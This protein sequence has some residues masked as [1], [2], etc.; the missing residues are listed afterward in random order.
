[1]T[2][3]FSIQ[4]FLLSMFFG[5]AVGI[6]MFGVPLIVALLFR[7]VALRITIGDFQ[8]DDNGEPQ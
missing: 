7:V 1:M 5:L 3:G 4:G 2:I 6:G 8:P